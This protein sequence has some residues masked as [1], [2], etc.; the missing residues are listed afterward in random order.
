MLCSTLLLL[1][2]IV[3]LVSVGESSNSAKSF[4]NEA[5][6]LLN[7]TGGIGSFATPPG[8]P[9]RNENPLPAEKVGDVL[10]KVIRN[11]RTVIEL[12][13][14]IREAYFF[15]GVAYVRK[16]DT[17]QAITAFY[18]ALAVE[19][20]REMTY[21]LLC[22][23]LWDAKR[24]EDAL[25]VTSRL[26]AQL[27]QSKITAA[28][29]AGKTYYEMGDFGKALEEGLGIID[30]DRSHLEGRILV[31]SS[32]YCLGNYEKADEQIKLLESDPR[33][34]SQISEFKNELKVKC[35]AGGKR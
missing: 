19:P 9:G 8:T 3:Q 18:K 21:V 34:S 20:D 16:M 6:S 4:F 35:G 30:S 23:I 33:I 10:D 31:A 29:L 7:Q 24:Y 32:Y 2:S 5:I 27:P 28:I 13:P 12:D 11:L 26:T 14:S 17:D 25:S 15:L 22:G 1:L